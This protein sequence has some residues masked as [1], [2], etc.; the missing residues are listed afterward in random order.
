[1]FFALIRFKALRDHFSTKSLIAAVTHSKFRQPN[2]DYC[3]IYYKCSIYTT[4]ICK[5]ILTVFPLFS[6]GCDEVK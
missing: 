6:I 1:M 2:A 4:K 5:L 3:N